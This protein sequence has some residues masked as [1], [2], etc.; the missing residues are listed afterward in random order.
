M[1]WFKL[2]KRNFKLNK[3]FPAIKRKCIFI[4][5]CYAAPLS[6]ILLKFLF[7]IGDYSPSIFVLVFILEQQISCGRCFLPIPLPCGEDKKIQ[8]VRPFMIYYYVNSVNWRVRGDM[9]DDAI[10]LITTQLL[11]KLSQK[12]LLCPRIKI[13]KRAF[14]KS[15]SHVMQKVS[16]LLERAMMQNILHLLQPFILR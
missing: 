10:M 8:K 16:L 11:N 15:C 14:Q 6:Q 5:L 7:N 9:N 12:V 3:C 13:I 4:N 1:I 2:T